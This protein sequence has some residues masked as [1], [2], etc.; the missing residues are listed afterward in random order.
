MVMSAQPE[1][2]KEV[3]FNLLGKNRLMPN[4]AIEKEAGLLLSRVRFALASSVLT[5]ESKAL[6]INGL[7][8]QGPIECN[9][10]INEFKELSHPDHRNLLLAAIALEVERVHGNPDQVS[11]VRRASVLSFLSNAFDQA[12]IRLPSVAVATRLCKPNSE[13]AKELKQENGKMGLS[14]S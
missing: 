5:E 7:N 14:P 6:L 12:V 1:I 9:V 8:H 4:L 11:L 10:S 2:A 13:E 3:F